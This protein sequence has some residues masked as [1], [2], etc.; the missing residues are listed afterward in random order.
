VTKDGAMLIYLNGTNNQKSGPD[1]NYGRELQEL[2][3]IGKGPLAGP[4]D[5]TNYTEADVKAAAHVL[6]GWRKFQNADGT[7]GVQ[8]GYFDVTRHDTTNK[9]FSPRYNNTV[10]TGSTD[11]AA[12]LQSMLDLIFSEPETA[13]FICRKLY[14]WFVY[15]V[16]D[17]NAEANV[18]GPMA[19]LLR[20]NNYAIL[21][22]LNALFRSAH[23]YDP[24][25]VGCLI[26]SPLDF[27]AGACRQFGVAPPA[28][29][30]AK[31][32]AGWYALMSQAALMQEDLGEPPNVAGW[33]AYYQTPE[34]HELWIN[35]DTLPKRRRLTDSLTGNGYTSG[36]VTLAIDVI[37]FTQSLPNPADVNAVIAD[38]AKAFLATP[39]LPSV[40][41]SLKDQL[42]QGY[43]T[44]TDYEWTVE[45][46]AFMAD[47]LNAAKRNPMKAK[48]QKLY[49]LLLSL[50]EYEL[51]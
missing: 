44:N 6:T 3:T 29:D 48:L 32:Y 36:G 28:G 47:Q 27:V 42:M 16:I 20:L 45:W 50:P 11:G 39:L 25:N 12:E 40:Q 4:G 43:S 17:A 33:P 10:I 7:I 22:T 15:Y 35:S 13:R 30:V 51:S 26:K 24:V 49:A 23:F 1:E 19:D 9:V 8:T 2:F 31:Q 14:R 18:I 5:Y 37:A 41:V 34:F 21:P 38:V 46:V